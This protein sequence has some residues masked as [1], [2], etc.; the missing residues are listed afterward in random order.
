MSVK[1]C[2]YVMTPVAILA[3][4]SAS[5]AADGDG[6]EV[7]AF[8]SCTNNVE[9][10]ATEQSPVVVDAEGQLW[11]TGEGMWKI[12]YG[13]LRDV[14]GLVGAWSGEVSVKPGSV[15]EP[16]A[17]VPAFV[18]R[19]A[20][21]WVD[22]SDP[23]EGHFVAATSGSGIATWF[24]RREATPA[25]PKYLRAEAN[26]HFTA[27][28]PTRVT[29]EA[30][31]NRQA[32]WFGGLG[33]G[34]RYN[35]VQPNG[36]ENRK[37]VLQ[38]FAVHGVVE[39][40]G[41]LFGTTNQGAAAS[42]TMNPASTKAAS[43]TGPYFWNSEWGEALNA[44]V[45]VDDTRIDPPVTTVKTGFQLME[46]QF[47]R[48]PS[49]GSM[50]AFYSD[51][52]QVSGGLCQAGGDYLCEVICFTNILSEADRL[53]VR[54]Y[55]KRKWF[56]QRVH[57]PEVVV[58]DGASV[59][60]DTTGGSYEAKSAKMHVVGTGM[61]VKRGAGEFVANY[62]A[63]REAGTS[64]SFA[65]PLLIE[66]GVV[67]MGESMPI[68]VE[69][70]DRV[71]ASSEKTWGPR[72]TR[73]SDAA[74]DTLV[75]D[76][77]EEV[78]V[79][80]VPD[81]VANLQV[82]GGTLTVLPKLDQ[83][84]SAQDYGS[85]PVDVYVPNHD[86]EEDDAEFN[87]GGKDLNATGD[88]HGWRTATSSNAFVYDF[89]NWT[90]TKPG[91][92]NGETKS[93]WGLA[94]VR[95]WNG[96]RALFFR[97]SGTKPYTLVT[98]PTAGVYEVS[99]RYTNRGNYPERCLFD[100]ELADENGVRKVS[101]GRGRPMDS[102]SGK[103]SFLPFAARAYVA[104]AGT[105]RLQ[106]VADNFGT[107]N[108]CAAIDDIHL[109]RVVG[110]HEK[111]WPV[112]NGDFE[113][114]DTTYTKDTNQGVKTVAATND[115]ALDGWTFASPAGWALMRPAAHVVF[116]NSKGHY[117]DDDG[118]ND[119]RYPYGGMAQGYFF[120]SG[121]M[122][123]T[124][125]RP[126]AGTHYLQADMAYYGNYPGTIEAKVTID[127][128][129]TSLGTL[130]PTVK[131]MKA[132]VF[133]MP[134]VVDGETDVSLELVFTRSS[135]AVAPTKENASDS[136]LWI[137]DV[138]LVETLPTNVAEKVVN[139]GGETTEA[140]KGIMGSINPTQASNFNFHRSYSESY[141]VFGADAVDGAYFISLGNGGGVYQTI[142][143]DPGVYRLSLYAHS[144]CEMRMAA[145]DT[146]LFARL[147]RNGVTNELLRART[148]CTNFVE[149]VAEFRVAEAGDYDFELRDEDGVSGSNTILDGVSI[150][151]VGGALDMTSPFRSDAV[152][153]VDAGARLNLDF[154]GVSYISEL[155]LGG[156]RISGIVNA[157]THPAYI[158]GT[159]SLSIPRK[160]MVFIFR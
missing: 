70:G 139:G 49:R 160:G 154:E 82:K 106:F 9:S 71:T 129:T 131:Q 73:V 91:F 25:S 48:N 23:N 20:W 133:P 99:L 103:R 72:V 105:Y 33:S 109:R 118:Y 93:I 158:G 62:R 41:N 140:W 76:G 46:V 120:S 6:F 68:A 84:G 27:D 151:P 32:M 126:P 159:G 15:T 108:R 47:P 98:I 117:T 145:R 34:Q 31:G 144:R 10:A 149:R 64:Q 135:K 100:V 128:T 116:P 130:T 142:H 59:V 141:S 114:A 36:M 21:F 61:A 125:F 7:P 17:E 96:S 39:S 28:A 4:A 3:V 107:D 5:F 1:S 74:S 88:F 138:V 134:F 152:V 87:D 97:N 80:G 53:A 77:N 115:V 110:R 40:W 63:D 90:G 75:K 101:F 132:F 22:A 26:T 83:Q 51:R 150:R 122:S 12:P 102:D 45:Y 157:Q 65:G 8:E 78:F 2:W 29:S 155:R 44:R 95:P 56:P 35:W 37:K 19:D 111:S 13:A 11:K 143:F 52:N 67:R 113:G 57:V 85:T 60:Y 69:A 94:D 147:S 127:G 24:D 14:A 89:D 148:D 43:L 104:E 42:L 50:S 30:T 54:T 121:T 86:F 38:C 119:S 16:S 156:R 55:L 79:R 81:G 92:A 136:G 18:T 146:L 137:D 112:P 66:A 124:A 153:S 58:G 123:C